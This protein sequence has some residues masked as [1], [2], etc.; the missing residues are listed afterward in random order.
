MSDSKVSH[1]VVVDAPPE[2][3]FNVLADPAR[4]S[5]IDG[6]DSVKGAVRNPRRLR[7]GAKFRMRMH[8]YGVP[9]LITNTVVEF[10]ENRRIA[11]R[12][13]G[14]HVWR[15]ELEPVEGNRT[16]VTETFDWGPAI[17]GF[18]YPMLGFPRDND[19]AIR[20]TLRRL[21]DRFGAVRT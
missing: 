14:R 17:A 3:I 8:R 20:A 12:H 15:W 21:E 13:I 16:R 10:E 11:W 4:H 2:V 6:S 5:E 7:K 1:S 18:A 9:Y 19:T